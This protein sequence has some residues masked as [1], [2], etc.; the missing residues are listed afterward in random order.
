MTEP[1]KPEPPLPDRSVK[2]IYSDDMSGELSARPDNY[3]GSIHFETKGFADDLEVQVRVTLTR[4]GSPVVG[5]PVRHGEQ[6]VESNA[7]GSFMLQSVEG[8]GFK[9]SEMASPDTPLEFYAELL[10]SG[11]YTE[12]I[13]LLEVKEGQLTVLGESVRSIQVSPFSQF[14]FIGEGPFSAAIDMYWG[15]YSKAYGLSEDTKVGYELTILD[16][17]GQPVSLGVLGFRM[18]PHESVTTLTEPGYEIVAPD[19]E[20]V[21]RANAGLT[22][23]DMDLEGNGSDILFRWQQAHVGTYTLRIQLVD[24]SGDVPQSIGDPLEWIIEV[25]PTS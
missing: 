19:S 7:E 22:V 3:F 10:D 5:L 13:E 2:V 18:K 16:D 8:T 12:K 21:Y 24:V 15:F 17:N 11:S 23:G 20:G 6:T 25:I 9:L 1:P 4:D 14:E